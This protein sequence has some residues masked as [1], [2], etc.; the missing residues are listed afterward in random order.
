VSEHDERS[1]PLEGAP[2]EDEEELPEVDAM[3]PLKREPD[4]VAPV[5]DPVIPPVPPE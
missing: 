2:S 3:D 1:D 4:E 5:L